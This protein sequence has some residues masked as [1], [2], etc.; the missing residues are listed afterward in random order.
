MHYS[1]EHGIAIACRASVNLSVT[2]VDQDHIGWKSWKLIAPPISP[3]ANTF[4]LRSPKVIHLLAGEHGEILRRLEV[5]CGKVVCWSTKAAISLK[6]VKIG[7]QLLWWT[8]RSSPTL[9]RTVPSR[10]RWPFLPQYLGLATCTQNSNRFYL[11]TT[12]FKFRMHIHSINRKRSPLKFLGKVA[13]G[14]VMDSRKF[15]GHSY[16][17]RIAR[18]PLRPLSFLVIKLTYYILYIEILLVF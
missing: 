18:S 3:T 11:R 16:I 12:D 9:F 5:G 7:E 4:A 14:I 2:L 17:G 10:P 13:V 1:A 6:R 15:L 8:Y